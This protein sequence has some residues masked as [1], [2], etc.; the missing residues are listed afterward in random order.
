MNND[1]IIIEKINPSDINKCLDIYN[2]YILNTCYTLEEEA[3]S[4]SKFSERVSKITKRFPFLVARVGDEVLGYA[5]LDIF[6]ERSAYRRSADLSIYLSK[7]HLGKHIGKLLLDGILSLAK[8]ISLDAIISI[9]TSEN[10]NSISFHEKN[11]FLLEGVLHKV[12]YKFSKDIDV[13]FFV[14]HI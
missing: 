5:Y 12:A 4:L 3:L 9:I 14:K 7:D 10:S 1:N 8:N 2:Y 13:Y 6:N 11:G